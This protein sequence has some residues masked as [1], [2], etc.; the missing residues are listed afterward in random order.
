MCYLVGTKDQGQRV[1]TF[2]NEH[3]LTPLID[4]FSLSLFTYTLFWEWGGEE[5][6]V[7]LQKQYLKM[8]C[9]SEFNASA[10]PLL[11]AAFKAQV[12]LKEN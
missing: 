8:L 10:S 4:K 9:T 2:L 11:K 3:K 5:G 7:P 6:G 1:F 12:H